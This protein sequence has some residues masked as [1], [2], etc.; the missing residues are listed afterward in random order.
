MGSPSERKLNKSDYH[1]V[2]R[3]LTVMVERLQRTGAKSMY[4][5]MDVP[6]AMNWLYSLEHVYIVDDAYL[7]AYELGTPEYIREGVTFLNERLVIRLAV[8][9]DF[10]VVPAF[11]ERKAREAGA[12]LACAGTALAKADGALASLYHRAGFSTQAL[13]LVKDI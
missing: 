1:L 10:T 5:Y 9:G 12:K 4:A 6:T 7:V 13:T 2:K 8:S 11:L 3:V